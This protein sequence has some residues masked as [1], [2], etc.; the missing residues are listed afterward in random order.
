MATLTEQAVSKDQGLK[1]EM[2]RVIK[3]SKQRVFDA[4]TRPEFV[5]QWF[6]SEVKTC[7][8]AETDPRV[9]GA[10]LFEMSGGSCGGGEGATDT[11]TTSRA[12]GRYVKVE[13]FDLL[14]FTWRGDWN[15]E[16]ETLVTVAL[17][18]VDGGTEIKLTH[19]RFATEASRDAHQHGW[20]ESMDK[21][22][23]FLEMK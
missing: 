18:D 16:E 15:P 20:S 17:R 12:T 19:E 21:L 1:L 10:Y 9:G 14:V 6:G 11:I 22:V 7:T 13:P 2:T 5:R 23:R 3:A 8:N 4:W